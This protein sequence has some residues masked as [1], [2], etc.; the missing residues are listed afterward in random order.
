M[1]LLETLL[2][3]SLMS[4]I[5]VLGAQIVRT[6]WQAWDV[7]DRR[8]DMLQHLGGT[9]AHVTRHLRMCRNVLYVSGPTDTSGNLEITLP[10]DSVVKWYHDNVDRVV[11]YEINGTAPT[12]LLATGIDSLKFECFKIDGVTPTT[13]PADVRMI[14]TTASV[15]VPVQGTPFTLSSTVW[16]R[17]QQDALA[18]EF[19]DFYATNSSTPIGWQNH[20]YLIGPP[21]GLLSSGPQGATVR[22]FGF[23]P[24][25]YT[26]SVGTVLV[27]LY[28]KTDTPMGDDFLDVQ[29]ARTSTGPMHSFGKRALKRFDNN[30]DWFWVDVTDDFAAWTYEDLTGT[31]VEITNRDAGSGGTTIHL[32]SVKIRTFETAP[33]TQTFWMTGLGTGANEWF[34]Q[35]GAVGAPDGTYA[36]ST[37][38]KVDDRQ[39]YS[40]TGSWEDLGTIVRV[41]LLIDFYVTATFVD[42]EFSSRLRLTGGTEEHREDVPIAALNQHVGVVNQG[43]VSLDF[44]NHESWTWPSVNSREVRFHAKKKADSDGDIYVDG[45]ALEVRY[46]PPN[47]AV[48]VLWEEL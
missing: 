21:D 19:S 41:R 29:L 32:D 40:Y 8:S 31:R 34:S 37:F 44:S 13:V 1:T 10:D 28:L 35:M 43:T 33:L 16:I 12:H 3:L 20:G 11:R 38:E 46:V 18:A 26:G 27:G 23:D 45:A 22:A 9:L 14:R 6:S 42:D 15:T 25:G 4:L 48:V 17:K 47:Q 5:S 2:A 30:T 39:S 36:H 7:Q 24:T